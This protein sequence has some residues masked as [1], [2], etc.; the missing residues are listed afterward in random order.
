MY[1][2]STL[3]LYDRTQEV[4][5]DNKGDHHPLNKYDMLPSTGTQSIPDI[6]TQMKFSQIH[7]PVHKCKLNIKAN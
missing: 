1:L 2:L 7:R 5:D 6:F 3:Q 4:D